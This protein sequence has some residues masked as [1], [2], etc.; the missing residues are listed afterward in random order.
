LTAN[1]SVDVA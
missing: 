1:R